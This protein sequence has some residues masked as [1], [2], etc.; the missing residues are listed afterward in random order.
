MSA[1]AHRLQLAAA[2]ESNGVRLESS[3][4][5]ALDLLVV[6]ARGNAAS[7]S[8]GTQ[9]VAAAADGTHFIPGR[10]TRTPKLN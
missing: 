7:P 8:G 5:A 9:T 1:G 10:S 2:L 4:S 3:K 6:A